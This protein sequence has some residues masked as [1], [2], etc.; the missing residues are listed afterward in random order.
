[1]ASESPRPPRV[2]D[3]FAPRTAA[4]DVHH[5]TRGDL[6]SGTP[7]VLVHGVG[8]GLHGWDGVLAG[9]P[10]DLPVIR[11]DLRGHG[12]SPAPEGPWSVDDFVAD[13][14]RLLERLGVASAHT[15]GFSLGGLVAQRLA[16]THP[17]AVRTLTVVGA[18]AGRSEQERAAV[19]A[20]L[21]MVRAEGPGGAARRSV[22]RWY[23]RQYLDAHPGTPQAVVAAMDRLDRTAYTHAYRVLATT[24]LADRLGDIRVPALAV[25]GEHDAGSPPR[26]SRLIAERTGGRCVVVP[27]ARHTVLE[28]RPA[29][30]AKEIAAHVR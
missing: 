4:V 11:Y 12:R 2:T 25:T 13:H 16:A 9:L 30:V 5:E 15:V 14:L 6:A 28:E 26:M 10:D 24:D 7:L 21:E 19:L 3:E 1:M 22:E 27:G 17:A 29:I 20:R 8:S 23:S 18:V